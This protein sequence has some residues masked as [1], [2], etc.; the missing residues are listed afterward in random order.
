MAVAQH[1]WSTPTQASLYFTDERQITALW[2]ALTDS[3]DK[4][5]KVL[6]TA[7][8]RIYYSKDFDVPAKGAETAAQLI[9]LIKA[10]SEMAYYIL[11][12]LDDEDR[13][14]GIQVQGVVSAGIVKEAFNKDMTDEVPIPPIV[15]SLLADFYKPISPLYSVDIDRDEDKAA[16]EDVTE[17]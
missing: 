12:H 11:M 6:N 14:K 10:Q 2:D 17:F 8:N 7:Y 3:D 16:D 9:K 4:K 5:N 15:K 1:G 13:R